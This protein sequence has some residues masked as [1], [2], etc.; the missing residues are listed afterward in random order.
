MGFEIGK[1]NHLKSGQMAAILSKT[2]WNRTETTRFW[3]VRFWKGWDNSYS[4]VHLK[5]AL[6]KVWIS[7]ISWFQIP[8]VAN[9]RKRSRCQIVNWFWLSNMT[10]LKTSPEWYSRFTRSNTARGSSTGLVTV[11]PLSGDLNNEHLNN[12]LLLVRYSDVR[13][14]DVFGFQTTIW[15]PVRYSLLAQSCAKICCSWA[16]SHLGNIPTYVAHSHL[17]LLF[18]C[19]LG[20]IQLLQSSLF[21][22]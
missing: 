4:H 5:S 2:I 8:I 13:Y 11:G 9:T 3:M 15:I 16:D 18:R 17:M 10:C 7:N 21:T 19:V 20:H 22:S 6:Q 1:P 14:S 12:E